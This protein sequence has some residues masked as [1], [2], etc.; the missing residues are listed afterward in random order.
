MNYDVMLLFTFTNG[1][2]SLLFYTI[3]KKAIKI[4]NP[5]RIYMKDIYFQ[6]DFIL[7]TRF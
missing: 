2:Y 3:K 5:P 1:K 4:K 6:K 7:N